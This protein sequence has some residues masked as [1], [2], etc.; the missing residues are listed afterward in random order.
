MAGRGLKVPFATNISDTSARKSPPRRC[1]AAYLLYERAK[2]N[3]SANC[4]RSGSRQKRRSACRLDRHV[5]ADISAIQR[6]LQDPAAGKLRRHT[7]SAWKTALCRL[8]VSPSSGL[9]LPH[10]ES[11]SPM[12]R[13][14]AMLSR[15][16]RHSMA[17]L[18]RDCRFLPITGRS[19][20][21]NYRLALPAHN[22]ARR[23][24]SSLRRA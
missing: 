24:P 5:K 14:G 20:N 8:G 17:D 10:I 22:I 13:Y 6:F 2:A 21:G 15:D 23:T 4:C 12:G 7:D 3:L 1:P 18:E 11:G 19:V 9:C 16:D